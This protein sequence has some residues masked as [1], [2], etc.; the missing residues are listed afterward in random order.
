MKE[1]IELRCPECE[2]LLELFDFCYDCLS[3]KKIP[4][5]VYEIND[6]TLKR[7]T[8]CNNGHAFTKEN[9]RFDNRKSGSGVYQVC[10]IC[11]SE[12][13][14]RRRERIKINNNKGEPNGE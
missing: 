10:R 2:S 4:P 8:H 11:H 6:K 7:K 13:C 12:S 9:T 3:S 5:E 1:T 14:K